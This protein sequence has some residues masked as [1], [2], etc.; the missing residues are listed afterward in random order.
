MAQKKTLEDFIASAEAKHGQVYDYSMVVYVNNHTP[1]VIVCRDHGPFTQQPRKHTTS[2]G[3]PKCGIDRL[4]LS[5]P[6]LIQRFTQVH[7]TRYDYSDILYECTAKKI[8]VKCRDHGVFGITPN[9]HLDGG[10]CPKCACTRLTTSDFISRA[11]S[12][13]GA[14]YDY[15]AVIYKN[16]STPV[17]IRCGKHGPFTQRPQKH[18]TGAGCPACAMHRTSRAEQAWLDTIP[19]AINRNY[20]LTINNTRMWADGYDPNTN[21]VYEFHGDYWHGNP[22]KYNPTDINPSTHTSYGALYAATLARTQMI[23]SAGYTVVEM[24]ETD[25]HKNGMSVS[26][27]R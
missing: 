9:K 11:V 22:S 23:R 19:A 4:K 14:V 24:W 25:W 20:P 18:L 26:S 13:H 16:M 12:I 5:V 10:G 17:E 7:G 27:R 8:D 2:T 15:S 6:D 3:C 21:T 1:V